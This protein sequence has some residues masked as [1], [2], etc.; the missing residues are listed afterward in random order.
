MKLRS[1]FMSLVLVTLPVAAKVQTEESIINETTAAVLKQLNE[2][3]DRLKSEPEYIKQLVNKLIIPHFDFELMS[4]LVLGNYW[5]KFEKPQ[6]SCFAAGFRNLLVE[7]YAYILLSY[8]DHEISY[9]GAKYIG[10]KGYKLVTQTIS[11]EGAKPLTIGYAMELKEGEWKVVDLIIDEISLL[12]SYSGMF[13][14]WIH[15]QGR[16]Y[17]INN[18]SECEK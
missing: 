9:S 8:D 2:N 10:N 6:Q 14:S 4:E 16:D 1:L 7:R 12:R 5:Q 18:F 15:T 13:Q 17:F 11:R 3:R